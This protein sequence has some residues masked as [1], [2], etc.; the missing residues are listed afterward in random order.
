MTKPMS[1]DERTSPP[2][3]R[4]APRNLRRVSRTAWSPGT[5]LLWIG[6]QVAGVVGFFAVL[7]WLL[8]D[9]AGQ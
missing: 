6:L 2:G 3:H 8:R 7:W 1:V 4:P 5:T 9:P